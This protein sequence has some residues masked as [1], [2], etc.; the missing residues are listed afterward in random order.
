GVETDRGAHEGSD[1]VQLFFRAR[2]IGDLA[3]VILV[4]DPIDEHGRRDAVDASCLD[5]LGFCSARDLVVDDFLCLAA[6][7][8]TVAAGCCWGLAPPGNSVPTDTE[9]SLLSLVADCSSRVWL[10]RNTRPSGSNLSDVCVIRLTS[11]SA[12]ICTRA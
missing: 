11:K 2:L 8:A 1:A 3:F 4:V 7:V 9:P 10:E 6:L 12:L 5:N